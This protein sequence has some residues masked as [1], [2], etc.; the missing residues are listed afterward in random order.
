MRLTFII[1][2]FPFFIQ[3]QNYLG[4]GLSLN[5]YP[6]DHVLLDQYN[7]LKSDLGLTLNYSI[8]TPK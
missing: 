8:V 5:T 7:N 6:K 2:L 4:G 1:L 3:A